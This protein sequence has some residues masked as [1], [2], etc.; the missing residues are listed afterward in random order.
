MWNIYIQYP[1]GN[2]EFYDSVPDEKVADE[3][4]RGLEE[5]D[6]ILAIGGCPPSGCTYYKEKEPH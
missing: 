6:E 1:S 5:E 4:I 2:T 3:I